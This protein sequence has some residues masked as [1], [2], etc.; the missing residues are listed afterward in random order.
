MNQCLNWIWRDP[1]VGAAKHPFTVEE[2]QA[3]RSY[4]NVTV[5]AA[6]KF[7]VPKVEE[8]RRT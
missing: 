3:G 5:K 2:N 4:T 8:G 1:D 7:G 6:A